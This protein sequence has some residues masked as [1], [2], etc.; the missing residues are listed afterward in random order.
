LRNVLVSIAVVV[1]IPARA[2]ISPGELSEPHALL[3]GSTRCLECHEPGKGVSPERCLVCHGALG[4]R[5]AEGE[6][7]HAKPEYRPCERCHV[8]HH[9]REVELV[10]WGEEGRRA[11]DHAETG[12]DLEGSHSRLG[13]ERCHRAELIREPAALTEGGADPGRT[14][15][16]LGS[17]CSSCHEDPHAGQLGGACLDCHTQEAWR[18]APGFDH[19]RT[20]YALTGRHETVAC[21][22]CHPPAATSGERV[23]RGLAF[24]QCSDCHRDVHQGRLGGGCSSCHATDGW[25]RVSRN[26]FDHDHTAYPLRGRHA[27]VSCRQCHRPGRTLRL[28]HERCSDCHADPH[29]RA[30]AGR[31]DGGRCESC[32]DVQGFEPAH[33]GL[34]DHGETAYPLLGAHRAVP[35]DRCHR[36]PG[37]RAPARYR[38]G[39]TQCRDCHTDP[40]QGDVDRWMGEAGCEAC[41]RVESWR[42]STFDHA[43]TRFPL[44]GRHE[45]TGCVQCHSRPSPAGESG[46][47]S[48]SGLERSCESCHRDPHE[49][50]LAIRAATRCERC[51]SPADWSASRFEHQRDASYQLDGAHLRVPCAGCH[52][53]ETHGGRAFVRYKPLA[54]DCRDCHAGREGRS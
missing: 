41:H 12:Y 42:A 28:R 49:G 29:R 18:P 25:G 37:P 9:G 2:Q 40:H 10:Y 1:A 8:E 26:D 20:R 33:F 16:G 46:R 15:L 11:F 24:R 30:F 23:Y 27:T 17:D 38:F 5:I 47:L 53:T 35:C 48:F 4:S 39:S 50:Q 3:E 13:C 22:A 34:E 31:E 32:H 51:H 21:T 7:L 14:F 54:S 19:A 45:H 44:E 36:R 43:T 52:P 6:G